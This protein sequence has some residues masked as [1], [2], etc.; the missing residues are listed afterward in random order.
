MW[1]AVLLGALQGATEFL[2]VSSSG[3]LVLVPGLI[4]WESPSL[5][6]DVAV[7]WATALAVLVY[8]RRDWLDMA[9]SA[10]RAARAGR[11]EGEPGARLGLLLLGAT[12][13]AGVVGVGLRDA[14]EPLFG[15]P[16]LAALMLPVTGL[17]LLGAEFIERRRGAHGGEPSEG[18]DVPR[19]LVI[20][21]AQAVAIV[22]GISRSG[23]TIAAGMGAG[24]RREEAARFSFLLGTPAILGAAL[25]E[26]RSLQA[27]AGLQLVAAGMLSAFLVGY[28]SIGWLLAYLRRRSL[29]PFAVYVIALGL[30]GT[31]WLAR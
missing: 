31:V 17:I 24:L 12:I 2:P 9:A 3:H 13:P 10:L 27:G 6:F 14:L 30:L 29:A 15:N 7:H 25:L 16:R 5:A 21:A 23:M 4:G 1:R 20:G 8:F 28:G 26:L 18:V 19:A 11:L 22:P